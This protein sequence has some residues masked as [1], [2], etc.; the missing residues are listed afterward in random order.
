VIKGSGTQHWAAWKVVCTHLKV[1]KRGK[2]EVK[3]KKSEAAALLGNLIGGSL[4]E[5]EGMQTG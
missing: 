2:I 1:H 4:K 3:S 5:E